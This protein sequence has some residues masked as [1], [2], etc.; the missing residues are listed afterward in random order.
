MTGK[1]ST[2]TYEFLLQQNRL[3]QQDRLGLKY[4]CMSCVLL[5]KTPGTLQ[6]GVMSSTQPGFQH[7]L[8]IT[9]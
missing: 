9:Q 6:K 2:L 5:A 3:Q 7:L 4:I 1:S 8:L